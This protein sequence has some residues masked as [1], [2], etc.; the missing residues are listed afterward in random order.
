MALPFR[1]EM[2]ELCLGF[3]AST[4]S[5]INQFFFFLFFSPR[6]GAGYHLTSISQRG[7]WNGPFPSP[8]HDIE[9]ASHIPA[10]VHLEIRLR[11]RQ[12][13]YLSP[14]AA[15]SLYLPLILL[16]SH[17]HHLFSS[18]INN[19]R[20]SCLLSIH[21]DSPPLCDRSVFL[22][23]DYVA[24]TL[25]RSGI[26]GACVKVIAYEEKHLCVAQRPRTSGR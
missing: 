10:K 16:L 8:W 6:G 23:P 21:R 20:I 3:H 14:S 12:V 26:T 2:H 1:L 15:T 9:L 4:I 18:S 19:N 7:Q 22:T 5:W 13:L 11:L 25:Q 24:I 17:P